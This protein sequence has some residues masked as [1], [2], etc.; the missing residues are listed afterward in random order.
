LFRFNGILDLPFG[1]GKHFFGDTNRAL[2][3]IIGGWQVSGVGYVTSREFSIS[4]SHWGA[5]SPLT[6]YKK[7]LTIKDCTS[8]TSTSTNCYSEKVWFNGYIPPTE[9]AGNP[10]AS[11]TTGLIYG[12][13][14]NYQPYEQPI[15]VGCP[16][17]VHDKYFGDDEV[18]ITLANGKTSP[19][20][21]SPSPSGGNPFSHKVIEGPWL[22]EFDLSLFKVFPIT[23]GVLL[24]VNVD[25]FNAFNIQGQTLPSG[26]TGI[27][28]YVA[29]GT[30]GASSANAARQIQLTARLSF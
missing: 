19:I 2:N 28:T 14:S 10:C 23:H 11:T 15:D 5:T 30:A 9:I 17:G 18:N 24:R 3:E 4:S 13:P 1:R 26:S 29:G 25:A 16:G 7:G 22:P 20:G 27:M 6:I 21:Y 8:S 12:L